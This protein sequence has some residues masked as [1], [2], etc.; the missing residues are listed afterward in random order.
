MYRVA[1]LSLQLFFAKI[2]KTAGEDEVKLVFSQYGTV[3]DVII[4]QASQGSGTSKVR[5]W[6]G[7]CVCVYCAV[8]CAPLLAYSTAAANPATS[9]ALSPA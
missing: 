5:G 4:F 1:S 7:V 9:S 2:S 8:L 3:D 6:R